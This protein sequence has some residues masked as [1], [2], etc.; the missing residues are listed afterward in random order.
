MRAQRRPCDK[1]TPDLSGWHPSEQQK[2]ARKL[3]DTIDPT[4]LHA[5]LVKTFPGYSEALAALT[6]K[7][8][9]PN[10]G[11]AVKIYAEIDNAICDLLANLL[12]RDTPRPTIAVVRHNLEAWKA[13]WPHFRMH[14]NERTFE[15]RTKLTA[16]SVRNNRARCQTRWPSCRMPGIEASTG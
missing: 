3:A 12:T 15:R 4:E 9:N 8:A 6:K 11:R 2:A 13:R 14:G 5:A 10:E 16:P 1:E 7:K